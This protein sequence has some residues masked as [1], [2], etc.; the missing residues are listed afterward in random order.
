MNYL[1]TNTKLRPINE[2]LNSL[3]SYINKYKSLNKMRVLEIGIGNGSSSIPMSAKF[4]SYYGIEPP[5]A[6]LEELDYL[7]NL[8]IF[9][10]INH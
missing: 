2:T 4:K 8:K 6:L 7:K 1:L 5:Q 3:F 9:W 10:I